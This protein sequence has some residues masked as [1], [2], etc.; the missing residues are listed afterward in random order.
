MIIFHGNLIL[1]KVA[2]YSRARIQTIKDNARKYCRIFNICVFSLIATKPWTPNSED[3]GSN[4]TGRAIINILGYGVM[5]EHTG[6]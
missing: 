6:L 1:G 3:V 5:V 4:P 2:N